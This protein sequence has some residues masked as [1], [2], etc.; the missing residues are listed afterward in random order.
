[1]FPQ[2]KRENTREFIGVKQELRSRERV[3]ILSVKNPLTQG[4]NVALAQ[5]RIIQP[6]VWL[7]RIGD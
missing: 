3:E 4:I 7:V 1:V 5:V 6:V 2:V